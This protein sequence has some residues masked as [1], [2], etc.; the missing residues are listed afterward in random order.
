[1]K[2]KI[3]IRLGAAH[4]SLSVGSTVIDLNELTKDQRYEARKALIE[5]LK[6]ERYFSRGA[7]KRNRAFRK[8]EAA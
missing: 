4:N 1:M 5:G 7:M 6:S 2:H 3:T 8:P